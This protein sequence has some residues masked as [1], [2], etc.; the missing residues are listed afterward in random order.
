VASSY[1]SRGIDVLTS[2]SVRSI[3]VADGKATVEVEVDGDVRRLTADRVLVAT[4]RGPNTAD[5]GAAELGIL[6]DRG[7][8]V[9]DGY[10]AT[11]VEGV[12]AVG[13]VR[14]TLALAHAAFAE[15]FVVADRIAGVEHVAPVDHVHTPRV[16][17]C[18][19]EVASV[20]LTEEEARAAYGDDGIAVTTASL[21]A[22]AKGILA[23]SD[24]FV[25]VIHATGATPTGA[26]GDSG[27]VLG[28]HI[29]GPHATDLIGHATLAT[30]WEALPAELAAIT[31]AHPTLYEAIG[32][33]F[34]SAAGLPMHGH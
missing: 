28:V 16:T 6:D 34:Q 30:A 18:H 11:G 9:T 8:A 17:Y 1:R 22:N 19:P 33:A 27:P 13:D 26:L 29:V 14:P 25:K 24:G 10:G 7:F 31:H 3:E 20:G 23:G 32:E 15:G 12:W 21:R 5:T 2:A 4:G